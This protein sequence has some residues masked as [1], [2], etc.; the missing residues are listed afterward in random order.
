MKHLLLLCLVCISTHL[1]AQ[2]RLSDYNTVGWY[3]INIDPAI[4][5]KWSGHIEYQWRRNSVITQWQQSLLRFGLT[6]KISPQVSIQAGYAWVKTF[7]HSDHFVAAI[8]KTFPEHRLYEQVVVTSSV[9]RV[10]L[11]NRLRLEQRFNGKFTSEEDEKPAE[12]TYLNRVRYMP[13]IDV[14][15]DKT[16]K[17]YVALYDEILIGFGKNIGQNVFDQNRIAVMAG[18]NFSKAF[19]LEAGFVNQ[20]VQLGRLVDGKNVFQYNNGVLV[21]GYLNL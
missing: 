19:R 17:A 4:T 18:Y 21:T 14:P 11:T 7:P 16:N 13:R 8:R 12:F 5:Q 3:T 2:N 10:K 6:Y 20:I 15:L 1:F 9:G